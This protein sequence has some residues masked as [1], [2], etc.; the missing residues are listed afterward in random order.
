MFYTFLLLVA[1]FCLVIVEM[2]WV[3]SPKHYNKKR[4]KY[5][6]QK[7]NK[8]KGMKFS[9]QPEEHKNMTMF[10]AFSALTVLWWWFI[11]LFSESW[12]L[13]V[14]HLFLNLLILAPIIKLI[15]KENF[16]YLII[17]W[18][19]SFLTIVLAV[20]VFINNM[21]LHIDVW[22]LVKQLF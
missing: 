14:A 19:N 8:Y 1:T 21:H 3:L 5:N 10:M 7:E 16:P 18:I 22:E 12:I 20:F 17:N 2:P 4:L 15:G 6:E 11:T 13:I 9:E